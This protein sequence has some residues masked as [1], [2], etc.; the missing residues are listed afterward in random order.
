MLRK[1]CWLFVSCFL[2]SSMFA[3][4]RT[5]TAIVVCLRFVEMME[6]GVDPMEMGVWGS[7]PRNSKYAN[8]LDLN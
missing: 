6:M 4:C 1:Q 3:M 8:E 2:E 7:S 5:I